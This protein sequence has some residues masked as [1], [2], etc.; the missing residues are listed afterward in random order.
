MFCWKIFNVIPHE[1][2]KIQFYLSRS[3]YLKWYGIWK[4]K[5]SSDPI[6]WSGLVPIVIGISTVGFIW[7]PSTLPFT[8]KNESQMAFNAI[9]FV[10]WKKIS[11]TT[12]ADKIGNFDD[13]ARWMVSGRYCGNI[14]S[15]T[16]CHLTI[17]IASGRFTLP[18]AML[19]GILS[20][21]I[22]WFEQINLL[23]SIIDID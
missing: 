16:K 18:D 4:A 22:L 12:Y 9:V 20:I 8:Y 10:N 3:P 6:F 7:N 15:G 1:M 2:T 13:I 14:Q 19:L 23:K 5:N 17:N 11:T 21:A